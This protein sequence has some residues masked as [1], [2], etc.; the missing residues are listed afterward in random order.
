MGG[1]VAAQVA[2]GQLPARAPSQEFVISLNPELR[3]GYAAA[4]SPGPSAICLG[5]LARLSCGAASVSA[6]RCVPDCVGLIFLSGI[7]ALPRRREPLPT[8]Q[9]LHRVSDPLRSSYD[10]NRDGQ[11][12]LE[13][14]LIYVQAVT[15]SSNSTFPPPKNRAARHVPLRHLPTQRLA[16]RHVLHAGLTLPLRRRAGSQGVER[17]HP[18]RQRRPCRR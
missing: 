15:F 3:T 16:V 6:L 4:N 18:L 7:D 14:N 17:W 5:A 2:I 10:A 1:T 13:I 11:L 9:P 12:S 8:S